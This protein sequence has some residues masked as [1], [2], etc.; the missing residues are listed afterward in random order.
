MCG[1][2]FSGVYRLIDKVRE[3][4]TKMKN[5]NAAG[6]LG[7]VSEMVRSACEAII[8]MIKDLP[9]KPDHSRKSYSSSVEA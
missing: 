3:S 1:D 9:G 2:T 8:D 7:L 5:E 4:I 6:P